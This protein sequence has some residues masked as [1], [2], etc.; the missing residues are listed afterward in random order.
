M[1]DVVNCPTAQEWQRLAQ[2]AC[3]GAEVERLRRHLKEC[4]RCAG[5]FASLSALPVSQ[6]TESAT[7]A[8]DLSTPQTSEPTSAGLSD[9]DVISDQTMALLRYGEVEEESE[10]LE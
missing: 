6:A 4:P 2:G 5:E 9:S 10:G 1:A 7:A 8:L 3:S